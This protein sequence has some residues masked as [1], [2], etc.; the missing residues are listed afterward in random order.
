MMINLGQIFKNNRLACVTMN[1]LLPS[2]DQWVSQLHI[3]K[4]QAS[5]TIKKKCS[6]GQN[7]NRFYNTIMFWQKTKVVASGIVV[8]DFF[9]IVMISWFFWKINLIWKLI[10][11]MQLSFNTLVP[12]CHY[13]NMD[14][15]IIY[16]KGCVLCDIY[17]SSY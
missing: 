7:L 1:R 13:L 8:L 17:P 9:L 10:Y 16:F 15:L 11:S 14:G 2:C 12:H 6:S 3:F 4:V 5:K